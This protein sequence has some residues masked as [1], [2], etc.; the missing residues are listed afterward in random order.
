MWPCG[1]EDTQAGG[2][3]HTDGGGQGLFFQETNSQRLEVYGIAQLWGEGGPTGDCREG[4]TGVNPSST[5]TH[6]FGPGTI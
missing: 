2:Q 3:H 1:L 6:S 4:H 5:L